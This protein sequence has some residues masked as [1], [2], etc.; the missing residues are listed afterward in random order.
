MSD[1]RAA[2]QQKEK[3]NEQARDGPEQDRGMER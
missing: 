2:A 1:I 3:E